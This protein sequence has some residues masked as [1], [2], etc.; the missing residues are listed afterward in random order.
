M[1]CHHSDLI[2][3]L[4]QVTK[5]SFHND[6]IP[7]GDVGFYDEEGFIY[8]KDRIKEIFKYFNNHVMQS[9]ACLEN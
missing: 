4:L 2:N 1:P 8:I 9:N 3:N 7:T 6:W 5:D